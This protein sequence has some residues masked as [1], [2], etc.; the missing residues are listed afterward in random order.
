MPPERVVT[1]KI[2]DPQRIPPARTQAVLPPRS[3]QWAKLVHRDTLVD[4][5]V[6]FDAELVTIG[7]Q[8]VTFSNGY[9]LGY[10]L[11]EGHALAFGE[12]AQIA[13][14]YLP[15]SINGTDHVS[16]TLFEQGR[17]VLQVVQR[18]STRPIRITE[19]EYSVEQTRQE[20]LLGRHPG[21]RVSAVAVVLTAAG[22]RVVLQRGLLI[23]FQA[24]NTRYRITLLNSLHTEPGT[25]GYSFEGAPYFL[26]YVV[27][28]AR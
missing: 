19:R 7:G 28:K 5:T 25:A 4:R 18:G 20:T 10:R 6:R 22:R 11:P 27:T 21:E 13:V 1:G 14:H 12:K 3:G 16:T 23:G 2:P 15:S 26:E 8:T 24:G 17:L 9:A